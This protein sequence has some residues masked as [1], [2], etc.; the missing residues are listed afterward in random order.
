MNGW[1]IYFFYG[2]LIAG[3]IFLQMFLSRKENK[4]PGLILPLISFGANLIY[5]LLGLWTSTR[6]GI[7]VLYSGNGEEIAFTWFAIQIFIRNNIPAVILLAIYAVCRGRNRGRR[8][9]LLQS[10]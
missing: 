8:H 2:V 10:V 5:I 1:L 7:T 3:I 9:T 4:W 6:L